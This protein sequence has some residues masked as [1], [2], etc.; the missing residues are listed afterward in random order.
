M[1]GLPA[2]ETEFQDFLLD[3]PNELQMRVRR[4]SKASEATLLDVYHCAY[5]ARLVE[6]LYSDFPALQTMMGV[7]CFVEMGRAYIAAYPS[8][9]RSAR[10]VGGELARFLREV[11]PYSAQPALAEMAAFEW[12]QAAAFDA[13][14]MEPFNLAQ[15]MTAPVK[16]WPT[17]KFHFGAS[18][19][20]LSLAYDIPAL[21]LA[22]SKGEA[23][24]APLAALPREAEWLIWRAG[25]DVRFREID[26]TE[27]WALDAAWGGADF[28][29]IC[30]GI[31]R[32]IDPEH[33][34]FKAA[35]IIRGWA[36]SSLIE[37]AVF[38]NLLST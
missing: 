37:G 35:E 14:D 5:R 32:W 36:D 26:P 23:G 13:A 27:A 38:E 10:W 1:I 30:E 24:E 16:V 15:L 17:L 33:A 4:N 25:R 29:G 12:A 22:A 28:A 2:L 20:R 8:R 19:R 11:A 34:S 31:C 18:L 21:W 7:P 3:R 9:H 6:V